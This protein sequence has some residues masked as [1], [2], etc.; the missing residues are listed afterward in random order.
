MRAI[1]PSFKVNGGSKDM[2]QETSPAFQFYVKEWRSSRSVLRMTFAQRGMYL[3]MLLEQWENLTLPDSAREVA[4]LLGGTVEEWEVAWPA[5][6][7]KFDLVAEG[8]IQNARL[9]VVRKEQRRYKRAATKGGKAR[10]AAALRSGGRFVA[11]DT[12]AQAPAAAPAIPPA[13]QPAISQPQTSTATATPTA[14]AEREIPRGAPIIG[15]NPHL[16]HAAC[17]PRLLWC[18]PS[19]VHAKFAEALAP[20]YGGDRD[21]AKQALQDWYPTVWKTLP[22]DFI[23]PEAFRF[24]QP[25]FDAAFASADAVQVSRKPEPKSNVP[26]A[27]ETARRYL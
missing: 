12:P 23:M 14:T 22:A 16:G 18:V 27:E 8:R 6:R 15:R 1:A 2:A 19:A 11:S 9:E 25:R 3:E 26:S 10:A 24:W 13:T 7:R 17:G 20:R 21:T 4:E 5:L